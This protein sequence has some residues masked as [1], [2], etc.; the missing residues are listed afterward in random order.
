MSHFVI[1]QLSVSLNILLYIILMAAEYA[2]V[3]VPYLL[4]VAHIVGPSVVFQS[5]TI[6]NVLK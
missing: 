5:F 3:Y 6:I 4:K 2:V 1:D